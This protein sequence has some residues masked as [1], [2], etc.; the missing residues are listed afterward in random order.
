MGWPVRPL[1]DSDPTTIGSYRLLGVLGNGGMGRVYMAQSRAGRPVAI[2][3]IR[4][5]LVD[6]P[7]FRRRFAREVAAVREVNPLFTA[8]VVDSDLTAEAPW[9]A[10]TYI[11]GPSLERWV[12]GHGALSPGAVLTLAAGLAEALASIH[13]AGL[14]HRDL[15][16]SNVL[17]GDVGPYIIDFGVVLSPKAT[18]MT[19][20]LVVGTPSYMA[21]ERIHGGEATPATDIFSLGATMYYAA[22]GRTLVDDSDTVYAQMMHIVKGR[23]DLSRVPGEL[24]PMIMRCL[25]A[26]Q[27]DRP[28]AA[29]LSQMLTAAG[30]SAPE[31]GWHQAISDVPFSAVLTP[32]RVP[33]ASRRRA[34]LAGGLV[35]L[36]TVGGVAAGLIG[37]S[38]SRDNR[39]PVDDAVSGGAVLWQERSGAEP[40]PVVYGA[41][42]S[43][44][45]TPGGSGGG[46]ANSGRPEPVAVWLVPLGGRAV[47]AGTRTEVRAGGPGANSWNRPVS[48]GLA[49]LRRWGDSVLVADGASVARLNPATGAQ[50]FRIE[51]GPVRRVA[52]TAS[53]AYIG[54]GGPALLDPPG[55]ADTGST[56][57]PARG[58][59]LAAVRPDGG[60]AWRRSG[61]GTPLHADDTWVL[62]HDKVGDRVRVALHEAATGNP[63][64]SVE[65][66]APVV[67]D[68][69]SV[70]PGPPPDGKGP[71]G[72]GNPS[73][74]P[75]GSNRPP[76]DGRPRP[77]Y[78][79]SWNYTQAVIVG[80]HVVLRD[81]SE[82]RALRL[83]TG[84]V[85]WTDTAPTPV[86]DL[87]RSGDLVLVASDRVNARRAD[88][89]DRVW[90]SE[91]PGARVAVAEGRAV[92]IAGPDGRV[93]GLT[94]AGE[95]R[96]Q[97]DLPPEAKSGFP[98]Q[99]LIDGDQVIVTMAPPAG[100][101]PQPDAV[102][103]VALAL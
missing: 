103:V 37:R 5:D 81:S 66:P 88:T 48:N 89:G 52:V 56:A 74:G 100:S 20:S 47:A 11:E 40:V 6:D 13:A 101:A 23:F 72:P 91:P 55:T 45:A 96:W 7:V 90:A 80:D 35:G 30:V 98:D 54:A 70:P 36:A 82:I 76:P 9:L 62:T 69:S 49:A 71:G 73:G 75:E 26:D 43:T 33:R 39:D 57:A 50:E 99:L 65:F 10:T 102:D 22:T 86:T 53:A 38:V 14:V 60:T 41:P 31:P 24:R 85:A 59:Y 17:L 32:R 68:E 97:T 46:R 4:P 1:S 83:A 63:R 84:D 95:R 2:K 78:T 34:L 67:V 15:K 94:P 16:P 87:S 18:R 29:E 79:H 61:G 27:R 92:V 58:A 42:P 93:R 8:A 64:W 3:V 44:P 25:S 19:S 21:P 51:T 28:T 77:V 12:E